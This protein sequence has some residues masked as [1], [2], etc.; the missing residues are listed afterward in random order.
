M[1][2]NYRQSNSAVHAS[3]LNTNIKPSQNYQ[4]SLFDFLEYSKDGLTTKQVC[5]LLQVSPGQLYRNCKDGKYW[6]FDHWVV[7]PK[8]HNHW[9][10]IRTGW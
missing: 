4:L 2:E 5:E 10:I 8:G 7:L 9:K 6:E 3:P 1:K